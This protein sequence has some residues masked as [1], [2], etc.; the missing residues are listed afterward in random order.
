MEDSEIDY[1]AVF[2]AG[3][4]PTA[5][6]DGDF[7]IVAA[8]DAYCRT[9]GRPPEETIGKPLFDLFPDDPSDPDSQG[10]HVLRS[11]VERVLKTGERDVVALL[12]YNLERP[13]RPGEFEERYWSE[14][15][16]PVFGPDGKVELVIHQVEEVTGFLQRLRRARGVVETGTRAELE[17]MESHI[18]ARSQELQE[19]NER[20]QQAH[21]QQ[22]KIAA[23]LQ[24]AVERQRRFVSDVSHDLRNPLTGLQLRL[25]EALSDPEV[26]VREVLHSVLRDAQRLND[27]VSDLLELARL[28]AHKD[29]PCEPVDLGVQVEEELR[30]HAFK[31]RVLTCP[32]RGVVVRASRI[33]LSRLLANLLT[34]ADRHAAR[35]IRIIV[36]ARGGEAVLEVLDDGSGIPPEERERI[37]ER[38]HRSEEARRKDPGGTG[39]G[40]AIAREI[41]EAHGGRLYAAENP[42]GGARFVLRLPLADR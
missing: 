24:E 14:V 21:E 18:Y 25:E 11:S 28:D 40:L 26:D 36:E 3:P 22:R 2:R 30:R 12:K 7:V 19:F 29:A 5:L 42:S 6:L 8:N 37:F 23:S 32:D 9:S 34:N 1:A 4:S 16:A 10:A 33:R 15:A 27:L 35:R 31:H 20:L 38:F 13:G 41:A 17:A 39:L